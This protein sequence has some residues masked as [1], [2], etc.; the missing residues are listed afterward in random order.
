MFHPIRSLITLVVLVGLLVAADRVAAHV[1]E[2]QI[3]TAVQSAAGL[4]H[5]PTVV[6][7]GFPF[8]TQ[9]IRGQYD[10]IEVTALDIFDSTTERGSVT[11][12]NFDGVRIPVSKAL[13]GDIHQIHVDHVTGTVVVAFADIEAA[14]HVPGVTVRAVA[15]QPGQVAVDESITVAG[16]AVDAH[17]IAAVSL[18]G[19]T[20]TLKA[21]DVQI[22]G[23]V[24]VPPA[25]LAQ[26][27]SQAAFSVRVPGLPSGVHLSG[28]TVSPDGVSAGLTADDLVLTR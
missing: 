13:S 10:H 28:V 7:H 4:A 11:T 22:G 9:A 14:S 5:K 24:A 17:A 25:V 18:A 2:G 3:A 1:A 20:L 23:G 12:V 27:K 16:V 21:I 19:N 26:L 15:G 6:V 8:V